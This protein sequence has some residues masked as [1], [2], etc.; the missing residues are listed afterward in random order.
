MKINKRKREK[1]EEKI[2]PPILWSEIAQTEEQKR[3]IEN[4]EKKN[5]HGPH[6]RK[7]DRTEKN[8]TPSRDGG[9]R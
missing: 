3:K 8:K 2:E 6:Q 1:G 9:R 7:I 4:E 5:R